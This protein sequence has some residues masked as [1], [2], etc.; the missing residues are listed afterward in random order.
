M[1]FPRQELWGGLQFPLPRGHPDPGIKPMFPVLAGRFFTT[2][3]PGS[4]YSINESESVH[5]CRVPLFAT[6]WTVAHQAPLSTGFPR[7]E[8]WS[9]LLFTSPGDLWDQGS[10]LGLPHCR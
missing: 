1:G 10:N 5:H 4:P 3:P 6:P 2:E 8:Y 9:G 7:Q